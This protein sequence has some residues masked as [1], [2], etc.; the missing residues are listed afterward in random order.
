MDKLIALQSLIEATCCKIRLKV[1]NEDLVTEWRGGF[2]LPVE[3]YIE[4]TGPERIKDV[5]WVEFDP[6]VV[7]WI[8]ALVP[9]KVAVV[10]DDI[11]QWLRK[12]S[13]LYETLNGLIRIDGQQI[14]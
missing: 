3:G 6:I 12:E 5:E 9:P 11:I 14:R 8:G 4:V 2:G 7:T 10:T 13:I 1:Y